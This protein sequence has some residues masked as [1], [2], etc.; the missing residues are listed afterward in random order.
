MNTEVTVIL[1][2]YRRP[3]NFGRI[4][5]VLERQTMQPRVWVWDNADAPVR[6]GRESPVGFRAL[7]DHPLVDRHV[8]AG[9]NFGCFPRWWLAAQAETEYVCSMDDDLLFRDT[10]VLEDAIAAHKEECPGGIVGS[11]VRRKCLA[12]LTRRGATTTGPPRAA[13]RI[14]SKGGSC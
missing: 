4:L 2:N 1:L 13:G 7:I 6:I 11:S 10:K 8:K 12:S 14:S 5:D 3:E 9:T